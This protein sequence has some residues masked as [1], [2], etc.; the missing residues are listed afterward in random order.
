MTTNQI[1]TLIVTVASVITAILVIWNFA[2]RIKKFFQE[3]ITNLVINVLDNNNKQIDEKIRDTMENIKERTSFEISL[4]NDKFDSF[5]KDYKNRNNIEDAERKLM[6]EALVEAYKQDIRKIYY[7]LRETGELS[8][9][10]KAYVDKIFPLYKAIGGNSDIQAKYTEMSRVYEK[11]TQEKYD[12]VY[13]ARK[14]TR[15]KK[16]AE[17]PKEELDDNIK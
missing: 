15:R 14:S 2:K 3:L 17:E 13:K 11:R 8:D 6:K 5:I 10:D 1:V 7:K 4:L 12:E 9:H 16:I